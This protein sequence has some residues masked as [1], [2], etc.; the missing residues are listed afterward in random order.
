MLDLDG[1]V[2][3]FVT[4]YREV[5]KR[6]YPDKDFDNYDAITE[7][8]ENWFDV[9]LDEDKCIMDNIDYSTL[10]VTDE[11]EDILNLLNREIEG[12]KIVKQIRIVT[13]R[14]EKTDIASTL[15]WLQKN[16]IRYN[17]IVFSENKYKYCED[18]THIMEDRDIYIEEIQEIYSDIIIIP[19]SR[20]YNKQ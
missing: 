20:A 9:T 4:G 13:A 18:I 12:K 3:D 2:V 5:G 1:V 15:F 10:P 11:F 16:K 6:L 14:D 17:E 19:I 8:I 7:G